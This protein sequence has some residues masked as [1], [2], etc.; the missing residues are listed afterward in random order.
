MERAEGHGHCPLPSCKDPSG[1]ASAC[2]CMRKKDLVVG[3]KAKESPDPPP[4]LWVFL[5][6]LQG[7]TI[8]RGC[9]EDEK[10]EPHLGKH[11]LPSI[12]ELI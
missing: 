5:S 12:F 11:K 2:G 9:P 10:N 1:K 4:S 8:D 3:E 7:A 6:S